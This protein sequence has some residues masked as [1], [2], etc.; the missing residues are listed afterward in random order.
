MVFLVRTQKGTLLIHYYSV[1]NF[2]IQSIKQVLYYRHT[3]N[4]NFGVLG[5]MYACMYQQIFEE[6]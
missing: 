1:C 6:Y 5:I 4:V 3:V 2:R